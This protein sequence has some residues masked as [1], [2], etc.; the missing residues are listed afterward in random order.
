MKRSWLVRELRELVAA[1]DRRVPQVQRAGEVAIAQD[2]ASL[3]AQAMK[4]LAELE[5]EGRAE[6]VD[7]VPAAV[8][9]DRSC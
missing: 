7:T 3:R 5:D 2:A 8:G 6:A 9:D 4:R 1:L